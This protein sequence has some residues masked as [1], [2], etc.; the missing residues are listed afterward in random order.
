MNNID[1]EKNLIIIGAGGFAREVYL[2]LQK[3]KVFLNHQE[4]KYN[5]KGFLEGNVPLPK[6]QHE[7]L[8]LPL[9]GDVETYKPE[10]E[11]V[12]I[13]AIG[14][15]KIRKIICEIAEEKNFSFA[16]VISAA[17]SVTDIDK[18]KDGCIFCAYALISSNVKVGKHVI[19]NTFSGV[20]HD[21]SIGEFTTISSQCDI[22]GN[23]QVGCG[24]FWGSGSRA[25]PH[26][27][28]GDNATVGAGSVVIRK[29]KANTTVF[30]VPAVE[31]L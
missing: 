4:I 8:P 23:V 25:I 11:D 27:K 6:Q 3:A 16:T 20:G 2:L 19:I 30:G 1:S 17:A 18:V 7:L 24:T 29:V 10:Q 31:I 21:S 26:S 28:I 15:P 22:T 13:C 12:F 5:L 14:N 9:L